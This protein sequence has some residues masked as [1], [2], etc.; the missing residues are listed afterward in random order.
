MN[1]AARCEDR[2]SEVVPQLMLD[3]VAPHLSSTALQQEIE[4]LSRQVVTLSE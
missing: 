4:D 2:I 1:V 3:R